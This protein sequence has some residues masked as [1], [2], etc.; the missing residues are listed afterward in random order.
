MGMKAAEKDLS[1]SCATADGTPGALI[2]DP[3]RLGQVLLNLTGNAVKFTERGQVSVQV[4]AE[5]AEADRAVLHFRVRDTGIGISEDKAAHLFESFYQADAST[6]RRYGGT[7]LGLSISRKL[8]E[9]MDGRVWVESRVGEGSTFHFTARFGVASREQIDALPA[10]ERVDRL[11]EVRVLVAEDNE[12]NQIIAREILEEAGARVTIASNGREAVA[13]VDAQKFDVVLMDVH[14]PVMDGHEATRAI[15]R[16]HAEL[17]IIAMT[18]SATTQDR[19]RCREAGMNDHVGKPIDLNE[20]FTA[21]RRHV[22]IAHAVPD[23]APSDAAGDALPGIDIA[24][25][26]RRLG[27]RRS[28]FDHVLGVFRSSIGDPAGEIAAA[29]NAGDRTAATQLA[30]RLRGAAGNVAATKLAGIAERIETTLKAGA[31]P[32]ALLD[33]LRECWSEVDAGLA[34]FFARQRSELPAASLDVAQID[35]QLGRLDALL[36][37]AD[38]DAV[39]MLG[40]LRS[41]LAQGRTT[42]RFA[43]LEKCV[44]TYDFTAARQSLRALRSDL[45]LS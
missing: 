7:G 6:T 3:L 19:E 12:T 44:S 41:A 4:E 33:Q 20:L 45:G 34:A 31:D 21:L 2:G 17:P 25:G 37:R 10:D 43:E 14:M 1:Y 18:A 15:R 22:R 40:A 26:V 28:A 23:A 30:H 5:R 32:A 38:A 11:D 27:G 13:A 16:K 8:V 29:L 35:Q 42:M 36:S 9:S 39:T 24:A